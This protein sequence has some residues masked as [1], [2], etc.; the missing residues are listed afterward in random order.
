MTNASANSSKVSLCNAP[1]V[2]IVI[3]VAI[4]SDEVACGGRSRNYENDENDVGGFECV[5]GNCGSSGRARLK[6]K[7]GANC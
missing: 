5:W 4:L 2:A 1:V 7:V 6:L 3:T